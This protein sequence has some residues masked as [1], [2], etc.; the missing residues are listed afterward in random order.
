VVI[1]TTVSVLVYKWALHKVQFYVVLVLDM[2]GLI[3]FVK[4]PVGLKYKVPFTHVVLG[5][6][7]WSELGSTFDYMLEFIG[8][9]TAVVYIN[10]L[11]S[12]LQKQVGALG[13]VRMLEGLVLENKPVSSV[14]STCHF[15]VDRE[16]EAIETYMSTVSDH[17]KM[18]IKELLEEL[19]K[20]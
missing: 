4:V 6:F 9:D 12:N 20:D 19:G 7:T 3:Y 16:K 14:T 5:V 17:E 18:V 1:V 11:V 10:I 8:E 15:V 2:F 13:V